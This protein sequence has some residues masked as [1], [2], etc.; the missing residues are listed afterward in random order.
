VSYDL[1]Q[2]PNGVDCVDSSILIATG[3]VQPIHHPNDIE[4]MDAIAAAIVKVFGQ[5]DAIPIRK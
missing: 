4:H 5:I 1:S 3:E 2:Y